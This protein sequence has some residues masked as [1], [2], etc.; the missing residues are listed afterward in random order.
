MKKIFSALIALTIV[1]SPIGSLVLND[2]AATVEAKGYKSGKKSFSP[3]QNN[4]SKPKADKKQ[5]ENSSFT[6]STKNP[7]TKG[8]FFSGGLMRGLFVGGIAGLLFGSLF[9]NMGMLGSVLG[10]LINM[11]AIIFVIS[12]VRRIFS[13]LK[14]KKERD[15]ANPW[16]N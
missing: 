16:Q 3:N 12:I 7:S 1:M 15:N 11:L 13:L 9:A 8:G 2:H 14:A 5:E 10:F 4:F 6:K